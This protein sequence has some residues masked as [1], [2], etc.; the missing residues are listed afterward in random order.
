MSGTRRKV[1]LVCMVDSIHSARWIEMFSNEAIDFTLLPSTPNRKVHPKI[2]ELI[3]RREQQ[4][5][6]VRIVPFGGLFS[7]P[8]FGLDALFRNSIRGFLLSRMITKNHFDYVHALELNHGGYI[9]SRSQDFCKPK[10]VKYIATNW[11]SD[12]YW[13]QQFPR[14]RKN[15]EKL[16]IQADFYSAE[17]NRDLD[18]A[19]KFGF[20]GDFLDVFPNAGGLEAS[21]MLKDK[22][23]PSRRKV[24]LVKGYESFVGR[25]SLALKAIETNAHDLNEFHII[26]YSANRKTQR[27]V[28]RLVDRTGLEISCY[29]KNRISH[30]E[31]LDLFATA[32]AYVGVSLSDG[33]STS[34]LEAMVGGAFPIQTNTSCANEWITDGV[35]G[36]IVNPDAVEIGEALLF[37]IQN[38]SIVDRAAEINLETSKSKLEMSYITEKAVKFYTR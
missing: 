8:L 22:P 34:L 33:I 37:A 30:S 2:K 9:M 17:C 31:M 20:K 21:Q 14:H 28:K 23:I 15:I 26:V 12:I 6:T 35:T 4:I 13:F 24:I 10:S 7:I 3:R 5:S 25:A 11:G 1:A 19:T 29:G 27:N 36:L 16:M 18:L 38:D 32:R